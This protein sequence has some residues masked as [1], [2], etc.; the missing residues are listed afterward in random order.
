LE[1]ARAEGE[2][3]AAEADEALADLPRSD[4][5]TALEDALAFVM[6]RRA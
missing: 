3:F 6:D 5:R 1:Y 4:V 2:R